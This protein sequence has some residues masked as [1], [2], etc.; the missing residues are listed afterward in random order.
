MSR[1]VLVLV[2]QYNCTVVLGT[3]VCHAFSPSSTLL[4]VQLYLV[5]ATITIEDFEYYVVLQYC[6]LLVE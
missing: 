2:L 3:R 1:V 6:T 4:V 5:P